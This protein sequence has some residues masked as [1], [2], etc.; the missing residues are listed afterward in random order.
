MDGRTQ[1]PVI[2]W[3][4]ATFG[5]DYVDSITEPGPDK[6]LFDGNSGLVE[7]IKNRATISV[8]AHGSQVVALVGHGDCAGN[9]VPKDVHFEHVKKGMETIRS[10]GLPVK[11]IG[12]WLDDVDWRVE[13]IAVIEPN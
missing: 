4:K 11:I 1:L 7:S 13:Q 12:I 10:W 9:P 5:V 8:Q 6:I 3:M 2:E